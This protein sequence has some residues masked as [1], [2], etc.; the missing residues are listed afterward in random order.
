MTTREKLVSVIGRSSIF[1][2]GLDI[3]WF[4]VSYIS[5]PGAASTPLMLLNLF[6]SVICVWSGAN[7][8]S[9]AVDGI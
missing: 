3:S 9:S 8:H 4:F 1:I 2:G 6:F 7:L 5:D